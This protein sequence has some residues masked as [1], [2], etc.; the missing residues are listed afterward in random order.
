LKV[1]FIKCRVDSADKIEHRINEEL[2]GW[3]MKKIVYLT[4][5]PYGEYIQITLIGEIDE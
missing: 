1:K 2:K 4:L 5:K 3:K